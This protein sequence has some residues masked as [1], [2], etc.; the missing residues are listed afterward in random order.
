[1]FKK[2]HSALKGVLTQHMIP[3]FKNVLIDIH[4]NIFKNGLW[5]NIAID[6]FISDLFNIAI[7]TSYV[8]LVSDI[9]PYQASKL[10]WA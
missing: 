5:E 6:I 10:F 7:E 1:M 4:S 3:I 9:A 2:N 8:T